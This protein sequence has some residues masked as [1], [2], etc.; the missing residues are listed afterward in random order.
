MLNNLINIALEDKKSQQTLI[1]KI[2][3]VIDE[4]SFTQDDKRSIKDAI[5]RKTISTVENK[6]EDEEN[7]I[8]GN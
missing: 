5:V 2:R 1:E 3:K 7:S 8:P 6:L 4:V